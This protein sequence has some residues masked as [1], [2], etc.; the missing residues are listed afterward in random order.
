MED[1][2][3][4]IE[5]HQGISCNTNPKITLSMVENGS[6]HL[7]REISELLKKF[8][9]GKTDLTTNVGIEAENHEA[10]NDEGHDGKKKSGL[11]ELGKVLKF[12]AWR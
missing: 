1:L 2:R 8:T 5:K 11:I 9:Y 7:H 6:S 3:K 10:T 12:L 4:L